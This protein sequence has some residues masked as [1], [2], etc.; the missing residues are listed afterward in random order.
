MFPDLEALCALSGVEWGGEGS[1]WSDFFDPIGLLHLPSTH[2]G[3]WCGPTNTVRHRARLRTI[4]GPLLIRAEKVMRAL[5]SR[6]GAGGAPGGGPR[7]LSS[8][9]PGR[10]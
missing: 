10:R 6:R 9:P 7:G 3:Y 8:S 1:E 4:S 5:G 2:G